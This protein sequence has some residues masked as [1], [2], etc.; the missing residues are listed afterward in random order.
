MHFPYFGMQVIM[1]DLFEL[2]RLPITYIFFGV[3]FIFT[4]L[5]ILNAFLPYTLET[6]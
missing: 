4:T 2:W 3:L 5:I 1:M 6:I